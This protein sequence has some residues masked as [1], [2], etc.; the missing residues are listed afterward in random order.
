MKREG[1]KDGGEPRSVRPF[2]MVCGRGRPLTCK[3]ARAGREAKNEYGLLA[4]CAGLK[5][6][7]E[8]VGMTFPVL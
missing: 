1:R 7:S 3:S 4:S 5:A 8:V 2:L 6:K